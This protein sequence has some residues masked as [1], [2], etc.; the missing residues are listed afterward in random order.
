MQNTE[1]DELSEQ[2]SNEP[3]QIVNRTI[4]IVVGL[5]VG[6]SIY[7]AYQYYRLR[8]DTRWVAS[9]VILKQRVPK[10]VQNNNKQV[11]SPGS[12]VS[13]DRINSPDKVHPW[14]LNTEPD[15]VSRQGASFINLVKMEDYDENVQKAASQV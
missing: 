3:E 12:V 5:L 6:I 2:E 9:R 1:V 11:S 14:P 8:Q 4:I 15:N 10:G 7:L 13:F